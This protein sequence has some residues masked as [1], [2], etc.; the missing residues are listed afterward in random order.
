MEVPSLF[1]L[2][3]AVVSRHIGEI[4]SFGGI[5]AQLIADA[6][7]LE[8]CTAQILERIEAINQ[9]QDA[10]ELDPLWKRHCIAARYGDIHSKHEG[11]SG[12]REHYFRIKKRN[13]DRLAAVGK[14]VKAISNR[15]EKKKLSR[16]ARF[17][18]VK[19][20][21]RTSLGSR[22]IHKNPKQGA[23]SGA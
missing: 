8:T 11:S 23:T 16:S 9:W 7:I 5:P 4:R 14:K 13:E 1:K 6:N 19:T 15:E 17:V 12:W 2:C 18:S 3:G 10:V 22:G 21:D 20:A